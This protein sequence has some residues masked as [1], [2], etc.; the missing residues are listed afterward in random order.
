[1]TVYAH[2]AHVAILV[3]VSLFHLNQLCVALSKSNSCARFLYK[4]PFDSATSSIR[5]SAIRSLSISSASKAEG[6]AFVAE[7]STSLRM[8]ER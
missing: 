1:M 4:R 5:R 7:A 8:L 6:S 2:G 3:T